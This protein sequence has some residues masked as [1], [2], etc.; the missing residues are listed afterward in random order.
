V[1]FGEQYGF[2]AVVNQV[3]NEGAEPGEL[4]RGKNGR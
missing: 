3:G 4:I 2:A 1:G